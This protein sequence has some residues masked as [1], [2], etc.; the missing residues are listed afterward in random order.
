MDDQIHNWCSRLEKIFVP[1]VADV[2]DVKGYRNQCMKAG[3]WPLLPN[4]T[5]AGPAF[6]V[7]EVQ[8]PT[9]KFRSEDEKLRIFAEFFGELKQG[10]IVVVDTGECYEAAA[11]GEL[12]STITK[13]TCSSKAAVVDGAVRDV[14]RTIS[15]DFPVWYINRIPAD[16]DGRLQLLDFNK[17]I[18]CGG[19]LV[20]PGDLIF[21]DDDGILVIPM[22]GSVDVEE[23]IAKAEEFVDLEDKT[24]AE[25]REGQSIVDVFN[26]YGRL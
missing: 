11:W 4:K 25:L 16:S 6:T 22:D 18:R 1:A 21:A 8:A 15:L 19:V 23:I 24:R 2:L 10:M 9:K 5:V 17:P 26:K 3:F 13:F 12:M 7:R 20:N 14:T